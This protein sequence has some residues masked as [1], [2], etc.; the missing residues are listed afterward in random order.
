MKIKKGDKHTFKLSKFHQYKNNILQKDKE[1]EITHHHIIN[2]LLNISENSFRNALKLIGKK[3]ISNAERPDFLET[4]MEIVSSA[5]HVDQSLINKIDFVEHVVIGQCEWPNPDIPNKS[6]NG[7][8]SLDVFQDA[9]TYMKKFR[10]W[11]ES[12]IDDY[13]ICFAYEGSGDLMHKYM[14][15]K[16]TLWYPFS[17]SEQGFYCLNFNQISHRRIWHQE[18]LDFIASVADLVEIAIQKVSLLA[19][20][21]K[22]EEALRLSEERFQKIFHYSP[23]CLFLLSLDKGKFIDANEF[24]LKTHGYTKNEILDRS[25][26]DLNLWADNNERAKFYKEINEKGFVSNQEIKSYKKSGELFEA[27]LSG[28]LVDLNGEKCLLV[29]KTD[30]TELRQ[31]QR[32]ITRLDRLKLIGKIASGIAH[33]IRNP[34]TTVK[35]FLQLLSEKQELKIQKDIFNLMIN[36]LNS[37]DSIITEFISLVNN[38]PINLEIQNLNFIIENLF[39]LIQS[40]AMVADKYVELELNR[41]KNV[42]GD[43]NEIRQLILNLVR[44]GLEA[45]APGGKLT[46]KTNMIEDTIVLVIQ[47]Q[48]KGIE[49][50]V[51]NKIGTPFFTTKDNS[52]GLGLAVCYSIAARHNA[53]INF[54]T[55]PS[56]TTF[57]V[58]F[59]AS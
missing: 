29:T 47:D 22:N 41:I 12:H 25:P 13:G 38:K 54:D 58:I 34:M 49:V 39:H 37:A 35:G 57:Y 43:S 56:G 17:F 33:E 32:E 19:T 5:L 4:I 44:N 26:Q 59:D 3:I 46:I 42:L 24:C 36:E 52:T 10:H 40:D 50:D 28:T 23:V 2:T 11:L 45:M 16:S 55:G 53:E 20:Q 9:F 14:Q 1:K 48:G 51:I 15:I 6:I 18:E 7:T 27:L 31:Y 8:Y 21:K 30:I